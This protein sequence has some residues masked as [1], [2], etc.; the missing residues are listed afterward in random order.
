MKDGRRKPVLDKEYLPAS[1]LSPISLS[2]SGRANDPKELT[3]Q[4][5]FPISV[6]TWRFHS[7]PSFGLK[8]RRT[9]MPTQPFAHLYDPC[10]LAMRASGAE[11]YIILR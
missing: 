7:G 5:I 2:H 10:A 11:K 9:K 6:H 4:A 8:E 3:F 1:P